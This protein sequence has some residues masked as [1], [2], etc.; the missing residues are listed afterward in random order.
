[1]SEIITESMDSIVIPDSI[2]MVLPKND[3]EL[4]CDKR[5]FSAAMNNLILNGIQAIDGAGTIGITVEENN[6]GIVIQVKDSGKGIPKE[7]MDKIFDPLFTTKMQGTGL[8]LVSVKS[9]IEKHGGIISVTSLP[10]IFTITLPKT[11]D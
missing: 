4:L 1:M 2:K 9:I 3:V 11:S 6:D 10:T 8:G 7:D 5:Q